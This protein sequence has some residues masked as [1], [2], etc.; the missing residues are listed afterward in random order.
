M[1]STT[2]FPLPDPGRI[3]PEQLPD[4]TSPPV[5]GEDSKV[6]D[7]AQD[8]LQAAA[9]KAAAK[10]ATAWKRVSRILDDEID[11]APNRPDGTT[12]SFMTLSSSS[13]YG[14]PTPIDSASAS[15]VFIEPLDLQQVVPEEIAQDPIRTLNKTEYTRL[16]VSHNDEINR[17]VDEELAR[18]NGPEY[19]AVANAYHLRTLT[20]KRDEL[21]AERNRL[22]NRIQQEAEG[23]VTPVGKLRKALSK[24]SLI[25]IPSR[26]GESFKQRRKSIDKELLDIERQLSEP[27]KQGGLG[28]QAASNVKTSI[29]KSSVETRMNLENEMTKKL[30]ELLSDESV[31]IEQRRH[32]ARNLLVNVFTCDRISPIIDSLLAEKIVIELALGSGQDSEKTKKM[33]REEREEAL[34]DVQSML[35]K[36]HADLEFKSVMA[37]ATNDMRKFKAGHPEFAELLQGFMEHPKRKG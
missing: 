29:V 22:D 31:S 13:G 16:L 37:H 4:N 23:S 36:I 25:D 17:R 15:P 26:E 30:K 7:V 28:V 9:E 35:K 14:S 24:T 8:A 33:T 1:T 19:Q 2:G 12:D 18:L 6:K 34:S 32:A 21:I 20:Q 10:E 11:I 5:E 3:P 27:M